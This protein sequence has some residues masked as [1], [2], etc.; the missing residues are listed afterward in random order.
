M[1]DSLRAHPPDLIALVHRGTAEY[2]PRFFGRDYGQSIFGW[3]EKN[4]RSV[5]LFG[6]P[7]LREGS[8]F[9]IELLRRVD[10]PVLLPEAG[11]GHSG[12][13]R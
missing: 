10:S 9:G 3:V 2:G 11:S 6:D 5:R 7:P 12:I 1:L 13:L 4:Y 8:V